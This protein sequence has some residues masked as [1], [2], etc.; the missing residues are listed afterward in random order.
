[1]NSRIISTIDLDNDLLRQDVEK[2]LQF[3]DVKEEYSE[4]RF[5]TWKNYVLWNGSGDHKDTL[6]KGTQGGAIQTQL[7]RQLE[8]LSSIIEENFHT[9]KLKMVRANLLRDAVLVPHRDYVEFK[10]DYN[11]LARLHIPIKTDQHSLHSEKEHVFHMR[12]G[13]VWYLDVSNIHSACNLSESPR[14]SLVLDF[15]LDGQPLESAFKQPERHR[16]RLEPMMVEREPVD[17][18]FLK[19]IVSFKHVINRVNYRDIVLFLSRVHFYKDVSLGV[20]FDWLIGICE[21]LEDEFLLEKSI[22]FKD[23]MINNRELSQRFSL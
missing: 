12:Q 19:T 9:D 20:F 6:F 16:P 5:G 2:I 13:E 10:S 8:Y 3:E 17:E 23:Y 15:C 11:R 7:G 1:M 18:E 14:I 4:Y 22:N 21:G